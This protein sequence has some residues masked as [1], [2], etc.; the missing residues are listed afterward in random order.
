MTPSPGRPDNREVASSVYAIDIS[1]AT[2]T[3]H[4]HP[5]EGIGGRSAGMGP[6]GEMAFSS[7]KELRGGKPPW[8]S[9]GCAMGGW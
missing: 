8:P 5:Q 1:R 2:Q 6:T 9:M 3:L 7:S 4:A